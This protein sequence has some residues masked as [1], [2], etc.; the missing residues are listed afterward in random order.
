M[1]TLRICSLIAVVFGLLTLKEG[2][3]VILDIGTH[4]QTAGNIVPPV[5]WFN[6]LSGFFYVAAGIGLWMQKRWAAS[7]SAALMIGIVI[8]DI[9]LGI[10]VLR[11]GLYEMRTVYAMAFRTTFWVAV[12]LVSHRRLH[13]RPA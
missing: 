10:H 7:L 4:R 9:L 13:Q 11:G 8:T 2:G 3:A 1:K 6:F 12:S 5:L